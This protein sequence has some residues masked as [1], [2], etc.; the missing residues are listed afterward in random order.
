M[1]RIKQIKNGE[2]ILP[3]IAFISLK[4]RRGNTLKTFKANMNVM[5]ATDT[6]IA[7]MNEAVN[8]KIQ[9][10]TPGKA[11]GRCLLEQEQV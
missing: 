4:P 2:S 8:T 3:K 5:E 10:L 11:L 1:I 9:G 7:S 6:Q